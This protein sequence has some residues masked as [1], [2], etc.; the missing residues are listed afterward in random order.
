MQPLLRNPC[1]TISFFIIVLQSL[2][3]YRC[4][5]SIV[6]QSLLCNYCYAQSHTITHMQT[7]THTHTR[8]GDTPTHLQ[9]H[10][11]ARAQW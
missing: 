10:T 11:H 5:A 6:A 3:S 4:Y 1:Y 8:G 9:A 7:T 2:L